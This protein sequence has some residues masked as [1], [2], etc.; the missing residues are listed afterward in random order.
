MGVV[1]QLVG[2][3]RAG[4]RGVEDVGPAEHG[5]RGQVAPGRPAADADPVEVD[6]GVP[7][8]GRVQRLDLVLELGVPRSGRSRVPR[9]ARG[10]ACPGRRRRSRR[11][12][13]RRTTARPSTG[14]A[15]PARAGRP[16]RRRGRI[17][18]GSRA[19]PG[20][21]PAR[22]QQRAAQIVRAHG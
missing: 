11:S 17:S 18:T 12:P 19:E 4:H 7:R 3:R 22:E 8:G 13:G 1:E 14:R 21:M 10:R 6:L 20:L 16:D 15:R 5:Q 9:P 2:H